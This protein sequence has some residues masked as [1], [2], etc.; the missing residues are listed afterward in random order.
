MAPK[1]AKGKVMG[2]LE[3]SIYLGGLIGPIMASFFISIGGFKGM[4]NL[5]MVFPLFSVIIIL[6][7]LKPKDKLGY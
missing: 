4:F 5:F 1:E 6:V 7:K 2:L 3:S